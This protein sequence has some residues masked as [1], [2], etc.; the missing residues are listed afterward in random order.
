[1]TMRSPPAE[2]IT[3][4]KYAIGLHTAGLVRDGGTLQIGIGQIGDALAQGLIARHRDNAQFRMLM[5]RLSRTTPPREHGVFDKGLYGV[6]EMLTEA[7]LALIDAGILTREVDRRLTRG[8]PAHC[9]S[10]CGRLAGSAA[11]GVRVAISAR[12]TA[13][14]CSSASG[15]TDSTGLPCRT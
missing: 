5:A 2:P 3:D 1:M 10:V 11:A 8:R 9:R 6:S 15:R 7:F 13:L 4:S 14:A 12:K